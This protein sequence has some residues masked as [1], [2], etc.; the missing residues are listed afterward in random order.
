MRAEK[1]IPKQLTNAEIMAQNAT[2]V[3]DLMPLAKM[4]WEKRSVSPKPLLKGVREGR[5][6]GVF[7][8]TIPVIDEKLLVFKGPDAEVASLFGDLSLGGTVSKSTIRAFLGTSNKEEVDIHVGNITEALQVTGAA[9]IRETDDKTGY[10]IQ[11]FRA[12]EVGVLKSDLTRC[13]EKDAF[14]GTES[15]VSPVVIVSPYQLLG[16]AIH[17]IHATADDYRRA[18]KTADD[19]TE[20][21]AHVPKL[22]KERG[23]GQGRWTRGPGNWNRKN[24]SRILS[25]DYGNRHLI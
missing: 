21:N 12:S 17:L 19:I 20:L 14:G 3:G 5:V 23:H 7:V 25:F 6:E 24:K 15:D 16:D 22:P 2:T 8:C 13:L 9:T 11:F 4:P 1:A 18:R 10:S